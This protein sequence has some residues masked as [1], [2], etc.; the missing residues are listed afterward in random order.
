MYASVFIWHVGW[1]KIILE[2]ITGP[3]STLF[4]FIPNDHK[5]LYMW[6]LIIEQLRVQWHAWKRV[7]LINAHIAFIVYQF[8]L[9]QLG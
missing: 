2:D 6:H 5:A 7:P 8:Y 9:E 3:C 1:P 4:I